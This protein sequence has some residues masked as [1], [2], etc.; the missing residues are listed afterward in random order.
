VDEKNLGVILSEKLQVGI[1]YMKAANKANRIL[2]MT[3]RT[4]ANIVERRK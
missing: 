1:E 4:F 3:K 2:E